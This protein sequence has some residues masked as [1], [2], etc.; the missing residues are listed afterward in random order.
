MQHDTTTCNKV[1]KWYKP[2]LHNKCFTLLY[3]KLVLFDRPLPE[4]L[5][6]VKTYSA[7][8]NFCNYFL[9]SQ[10]QS[11]HTSTYTVFTLYSA[12]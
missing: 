7:D 2:F 5:K 12:V 11:Q 1:V 6:L 8:D 4:H 9:Q 10:M 3:E